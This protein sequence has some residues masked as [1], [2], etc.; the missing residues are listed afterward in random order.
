MTF[1]QILCALRGHDKEMTYKGDR[2]YLRCVTCGQESAGWVCDYPPP[3]VKYRRL[4]RFKARLG[5]A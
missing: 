5:K 1:H 3:I 2:I 4:L